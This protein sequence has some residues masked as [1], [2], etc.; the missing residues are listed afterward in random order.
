VTGTWSELERQS[1]G[2]L[3]AKFVIDF[4]RTLNES[5]HE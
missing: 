4:D 3:L 1:F 2:E 5:E